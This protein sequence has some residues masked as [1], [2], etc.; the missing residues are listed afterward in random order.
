MSN[1]PLSVPGFAP[2]ETYRGARRDSLNFEACG[3][4]RHSSH[5]FA[6]RPYG[7]MIYFPAKIAK[8]VIERF[9]REDVTMSN[10]N[11]A[12]SQSPEVSASRTGAGE[13]QRKET[14]VSSGPVRA[15]VSARAGDVTVHVGTGHDVEVTLR[16]NSARDEH[17]LELAEVSYD[18]KS[19]ELE[20]RTQ[21]TGSTKKWLD[22]GRS[23]LDVLVVLPAQSSLEVATVSGD[24]VVYGALE[25]VK[26]SCV[27][28]DV[29]LNDSSTTLDVRTASGDVHTGRVL[30]SL[31]CKSASGDVDCPGAATKTEIMS[32]SGD[33]V[34]SA[35]RPGEVVVRA[36]SGDVK[37]RVARGLSV[38]VNGR[39]VS[40]DM[41]SNIDLDSSGD[42]KD[43][44]EALYIKVNTVSGDIRIDK[45]S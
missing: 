5:D 11:E 3:G 25:H 42:A 28:G 27:S 14:F 7:Q 43:S 38:D 4:E 24:T 33:V 16:V 20:I 41:G 9:N 31:K 35:D 6:L 12:A 23:D 45:A 17:L 30:E 15:K 22:F 36:V 8:R 26:V 1:F 37:V 29:R 40:G 32:A 2:P 39:T 34:V 13:R 44:E 18:A 21:R 10:H 19:N